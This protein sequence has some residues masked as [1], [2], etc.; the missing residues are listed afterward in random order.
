M[1]LQDRAASYLRAFP[2]CQDAVWVAGGGRWLYG[3]WQIGQNYTNASRYYGAYPHGFIKRVMALY[4]EHAAPKFPG[5]VLHVFS[6]SLPKSDQYER[7]DVAQDAEIQ[8]S[9]YDLPNIVLNYL[10]RLVIADPPYSPDDAEKYGTP[11]VNR[12]K[13][14]RALAQVT[15]PG[16][17]LVW[18]DTVW[19]M[20]RK[21]EWHYYGAIQ[22][23]RSTNH[24][25]RLVS[26]FERKAA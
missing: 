20:H 6:G 1:S 2:Q 26:L 11:S 10:P 4:P 13:A 19:P 5:H 7:C 24:R 21:A 15:E 17:H 23:I 12:G 8:A 16:G 22:L 18:L 3:C 9:V 14:M 25:V